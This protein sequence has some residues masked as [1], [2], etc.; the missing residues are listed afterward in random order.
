MKNNYTFADGGPSPQVLVDVSHPERGG[1]L[2]M[3]FFLGF[4]GSV[5]A[6]IIL[7]ITYVN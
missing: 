4:I 3:V 1:D 5:A 7:I 2:I 6:I